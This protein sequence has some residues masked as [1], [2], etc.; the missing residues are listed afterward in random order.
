M[1]TKQKI[2][3][4]SG[5]LLLLVGVLFWY[6]MFD[7]RS[8]SPLV[9]SLP[10]TLKPYADE[11]AEIEKVQ[12]QNP[13]QSQEMAEALIERLPGPVKKWFD[14]AT[15]A[16]IEDIMFYGKVVDQHG[17]PL[18]GAIV[19]YDAAGKF[20]G[21]GSGLGYVKS[22]ANGHFIIDVHGGSLNV[23][24]A[25]YPDAMGAASLEG[26]KTNWGRMYERGHM[27]W[28]YKRFKGS[29]NLVWTDYSA[30]NPFVIDL[31]VVDRK[32]ADFHDPHIW[33]TTKDIR[34]SPDGRAYTVKFAERE[35][36]VQITEGVQSDGDLVVS[37]EHEL[38]TSLEDRGKL[39]WR[40]TIRPVDGGIQ[41]TTDRYLNQAPETGYLPSIEI[42]QQVGSADY[43]TRLHDQRYYFTAHNGQMY[44]SLFNEYEPFNMPFNFKTKEYDAQYCQ[45]YLEFKVNIGGYRYLFKNRRGLL[46]EEK[47][48]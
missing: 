25:Q 6:A 12:S 46:Y 16:G 13:E 47:T 14:L 32:E 5:I 26:E 41:E 11:I 48:S 19:H 28:S 9:S 29:K 30:D 39:D 38:M 37:C 18:E 43:Q 4:G 22:D 2:I 44:G 40:V 21:S 23:M 15:K 36:V 33:W 31:W 7:D 35:K 17:N 10:E 34:I 27:F 42:A 8:E 20:Y 45:L 24:G 1:S 3:L